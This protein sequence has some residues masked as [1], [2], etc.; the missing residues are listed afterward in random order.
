VIGDVS[1]EAI[2]NKYRDELIRYASML[3][4]PADAED[5]LST[6]VL[7][8][9]NRRSLTDL[10]DPRPFLYRGVANEARSLIRRR[11]E[12]PLSRLLTSSPPTSNPKCWTLF[13]N[14]RVGRGLTPLA[15]LARSVDLMADPVWFD[16]NTSLEPAAISR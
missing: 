2:W 12:A 15:G 9:L 6:V 3:V 5:L 8:V 13:S 4:G 7:R 16:D 11:R 14:C 1:D 10:D